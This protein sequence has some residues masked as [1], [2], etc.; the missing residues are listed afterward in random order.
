MVAKNLPQKVNSGE[1]HN[2]VEQGGRK[3]DDAKFDIVHLEIA[4]GD[5]GGDTGEG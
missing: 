1:D 3:D 5:I 2:A 4:A